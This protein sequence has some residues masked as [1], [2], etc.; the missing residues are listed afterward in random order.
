MFSSV[1]RHIYIHWPFC[2]NKCHYCDF[3]AFEKHEKYQG[4]YHHAL[5]GEISYFASQFSDEERASEKISTLYIGGG[6][7]SLWPLEMFEQTMG[8][9]GSLFDMTH[10][11]EATLEVNPGN[12]GEKEL[13]SWKKHGI[14]RL[15]IGV[16]ILDDEVLFKLNRRQKTVDV[17][18]LLSLAPA[19]FDHLS[20]DLILGL[21]GV[22]ELTWWESLEYLVSQPIDH[23]SIY[24]LMIHEN[25][26]LYHR[27]KNKT[28]FIPDDSLIVPL[29]EKTI[30]YLADKGFV[31][32]E[33]SN[34]A[35]SGG[36]SLHNQ[37]YWD[38]KPYKGF[39]LGASSFDGIHRTTNVKNFLKYMS[40]YDKDIVSGSLDLEN[41]YYLIEELTDDQV[42][43]EHLML[44]LRQKKGMDLHRVVY[45]LKRDKKEQFLRKVSFLK[46]CGL[47]YESQDRLY[48]TMRG[49]ILENQVVEEL[50]V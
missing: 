28:L 23:I 8:Q 6:T 39:G 41:A 18:E 19:Y 12:V 24:F 26:P 38:R 42:F 40:C 27:V 7:P 10:L 13:A 21:P 36:E 20:A 9:L 16:Q 49:M 37:S 33:T 43:L 15:S 50:I 46:E 35:R 32:Y 34:F 14:T 30:A 2:K 5:G 47:M 1:P 29:Y 45:S 3:V 17:K 25:T 11:D 44:G 48:L 22:S 31:Q 4:Q